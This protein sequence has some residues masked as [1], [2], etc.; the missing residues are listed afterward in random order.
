MS[1]EPPSSS[2]IGPGRSEPAPLPPPEGAAPPRRLQTVPGE[3]CQSPD[4]EECPPSIPPQEAYKRR[5]QPTYT[6]ANGAIVTAFAPCCSV[7]CVR[8]TSEPLVFYIFL[9]TTTC[10]AMRMSTSPLT[11]TVS[12]AVNVPAGPLPASLNE[13]AG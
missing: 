8:C 7:I 9:S 10:F 4:C 5:D 6:T 1:E 13:D 11:C 12:L 3:I 2:S